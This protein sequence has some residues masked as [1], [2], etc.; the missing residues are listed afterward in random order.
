M[1]EGETSALS[2]KFW[3]RLED[4]RKFLGCGKAPME[5]EQKGR[6]GLVLLLY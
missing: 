5:I 2:L 4:V 3:V 1:T 6:L